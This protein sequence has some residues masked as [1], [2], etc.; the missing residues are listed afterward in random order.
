[1][2]RGADRRA[3][4]LATWVV[5][6]LASAVPVPG[7][8][9]YGACSAVLPLVSAAFILILLALDLGALLKVGGLRA[10]V[11][12]TRPASPEAEAEAGE[13]SSAK[14]VPTVD[15]GFGDEERVEIAPPGAVYR[16]RERPLRVFRGSLEKAR[17]ALGWA[18][19]TD[20]AA[21]VAVAGCALYRA[22]DLLN[23][24]GGIGASENNMWL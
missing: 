15:F 17:A 20:V 1:V 3:V 4:W 24:N 19:F 8:S 5:M 14:V 11:A 18:I 23:L 10:R 21:L 6:A 22:H 9:R 7:V 16:D 2:V 13:E 12:G